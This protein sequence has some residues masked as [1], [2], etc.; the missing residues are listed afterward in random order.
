MSVII[1]RKGQLQV[2]S[3]L[4]LNGEISNWIY[5]WDKLSDR[6][7]ALKGEW[8][9]DT[10]LIILDEFHKHSKW[11]TWIKGEFDTGNESHM[12]QHLLNRVPALPVVVHTYAD[13]RRVILAGM[14]LVPLIP[15]SYKYLVE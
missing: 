7:I 10:E 4:L 11:K 15:F 3:C 2:V 6:R 8:P 1:D 5:N 13:L 12:L 9:P 14:I